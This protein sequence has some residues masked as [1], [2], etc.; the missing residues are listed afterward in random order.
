[1]DRR[2]VLKLLSLS[3]LA[4]TAGPL[5]AGCGEDRAGG[6]ASGRGV[7]LVAADVPRAAGDEAAVPGVVAAMHATGGRLFGSLGAQ[8]QDNLAISPYSIAVALALTANGAAG[9]TRKQL[10]LVFGGAGIEE[11]NAGLN[12]L[13]VH[14]ES[15]AGE[16]RK[17]DGTRTELEL[18]SANALFGQRRVEWQQPFLET[19]AASYGAGMNA[20]DWAEDTEGARAAVNAWTAE[21]TRD[22]VGEIL[23]AGAVDRDTRLVLVNTLYLKAPW[24]EP[25]EKSLTQEGAF[26]LLDGSTVDV[27]LMRGDE[28]TADAFAR[29]DGWTAAR[30]PYAG[31]R[32]AMTVVLPEAGAWADVE[33]AVVAGGAADYLDALQPSGVQLTLPRWTFR[34]HGSLVDG[35]EAMGVELPFSAGSAD[36][37][38]MTEEV[39]LYLSGV[40][41]EVFIAVD[42]EGTEAAAATAVVAS[43]T[44]APVLEPFVV[45]RPFLFVIHDVERGTPLFLGRVL[46][47]RG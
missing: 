28:G 26:T 24:E 35:L 20:V 7:E 4:V 37:S 32:M 40:E 41:H 38:A 36:L 9:E 27:P 43:L 23:P 13:T 25:F 6:G 14:V 45:D 19:L 34:F 29:G 22:K 10:E 16:V 3:A 31:G 12:A 1:M 47:P 17:S 42:E 11:V 2:D 21:R 30:L 44:S 15:L 46:D 5:L 39:E 18:D 33:A 8:T